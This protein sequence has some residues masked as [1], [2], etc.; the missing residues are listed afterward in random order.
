VTL[1]RP[2]GLTELHLIAEAG[3]RAFPPRLPDQPIFY[4]VLNFE[5]AEEIARD[6]NA[7]TAPFAGFVTRFEVR[8]EIATRY[9]IQVVGSERTHLELWV[10]AEELE[11]F[12]QALLGRIEVVASYY[13]PA[14]EGLLD[15]DGWP[16]GVLR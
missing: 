2:A 11:T 14:F 5:Y 15:A 6:W 16:V 4:P 7:T 8:S 9:A 12:N 3:Y 10:P 13:G 1:F